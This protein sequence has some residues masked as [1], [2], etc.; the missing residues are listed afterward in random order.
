MPDRTTALC[1]SHVVDATIDILNAEDAP[2]RISNCAQSQQSRYGCLWNALS[3]LLIWREAAFAPPMAGSAMTTPATAPVAWMLRRLSAS[4]GPI[5][6]PQALQR[7][8]RQVRKTCPA[9][10]THST[11]GTAEEPGAVGVQ[12]ARTNVGGAPKNPDRTQADSYDHQRL[13]S[14]CRC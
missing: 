12:E 3:V 7:P 11:H 5:G 4:L 2:P 6:K 14:T 10:T 13:I 8:E 1:T 9:G